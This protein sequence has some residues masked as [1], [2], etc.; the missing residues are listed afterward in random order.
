MQHLS[1]QEKIDEIYAILYKQESR[2]KKALW[3]LWTKRVVVWGLIVFVAIYPN[4]IYQVFTDFFSP[5]IKKQVHQ[6]LQ[7]KKHQAIQ[8]LQDLKGSLRVPSSTK[9]DDY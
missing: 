1:P 6:V 2:R 8:S 5:I 4:K 3:Y 7:D 9:K